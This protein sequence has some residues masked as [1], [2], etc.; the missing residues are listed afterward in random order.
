[1]P[2]A[3]LEHD[4]SLAADAGQPASQSA[5]PASGGNV[6]KIRDI[7]FG[8]QIKNYEVRFARVEET[9]ARET[10]EMKELHRKR[11]DSLEA[12]F[13]KEAES[14]AARLKQER[15]ERTDS[16][17]ELSLQ[18]KESSESLAGKIANLDE[19]TAGADSGLRAELMEESKKLQEE[20][21]SRHEDLSA[22]VEK[23]VQ[24]L[25]HDKTDRSSLAAFLTEMAIR[26]SDDVPQN[27]H[28]HANG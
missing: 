17:R 10:F 16:L 7:L 21:R 13:K 28:S 8:A 14:L 9:L 15:Q 12:Y 20:I 19:R 27:N 5:E 2:K 26:L 22:L 4:H 24:E 11:F 25:R 6:D 1:M 18:L 23:R 3:S